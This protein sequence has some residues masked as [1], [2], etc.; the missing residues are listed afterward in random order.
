MLVPRRASFHEDMLQ[1]TT[2]IHL[3]NAQPIFGVQ[4][5]TAISS[6]WLDKFKND[7]I[8]STTDEPLG[9]ISMNVVG[10]KRN[11]GQANLLSF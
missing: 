3:H 2:Y 9:P 10:C 7:N 11:E 6:D 1:I 5:N 4:R 8:C